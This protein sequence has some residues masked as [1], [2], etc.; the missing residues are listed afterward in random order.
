MFEYKMTT[1]IVF[2]RGSA[3]RTAEMVKKAGGTKVII[4]TDKGVW[5]N[6]ILKNIEMSLKKESIEFTI[7]NEVV[8]LCMASCLL[9][10]VPDSFFRTPS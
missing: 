2:G 5:D 1:E 4:V 3:L 7:F 10:V 8:I 9:R 6:K